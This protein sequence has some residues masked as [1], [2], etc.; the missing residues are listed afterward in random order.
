VIGADAARLGEPEFRDRALDGILVGA[1]QL[2]TILRRV[3]GL[4]L[5]GDAVDGASSARD[6]RLARERQCSHLGEL[7]ERIMPKST[8]RVPN[9]RRSLP[10]SIA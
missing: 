4:N 7:H 10:Y 2:R 1:L 5:C 6:D 8:M 3:G 9:W